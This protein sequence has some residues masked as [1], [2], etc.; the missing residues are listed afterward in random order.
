MIW[1]LQRLL[2]MG[3]AWKTLLR[4]EYSATGGSPAPAGIQ[5]PPAEGGDGRDAPGLS[6]CPGGM[7]MGIPSLVQG[8]CIWKSPTFLLGTW[9][10]IGAG[11]EWGPCCRG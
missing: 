9:R 6:V 3:H 7:C 4:R 1:E 10:E 11:E 2:G 8:A 5:G